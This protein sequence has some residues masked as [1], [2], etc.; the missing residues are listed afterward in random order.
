M[1]VWWMVG[2]FSLLSY[3]SLLFL[4]QNIKNVESF[5]FS[6]TLLS[7]Y[8][9]FSTNNSSVPT[10]LS[11]C[12]SSAKTISLIT[13]TNSS[14][15]KFQIGCWRKVGECLYYFSDNYSLPTSPPS[16]P[17]LLSHENLIFRKTNWEAVVYYLITLSLSLCVVLGMF[18]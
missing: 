8:L 15:L 16:S 12:I 18:Q 2:V 9:I 7:S 14:Q 3:Q 1:L 17:P 5:G 13:K 4:S 6:K 11:W 10:E